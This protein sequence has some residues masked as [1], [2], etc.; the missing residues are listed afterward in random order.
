MFDHLDDTIT[1]P[2]DERFRNQTMRRGRRLRRRRRVAAGATACGSTLLLGAAGLT[3]W[4]KE[5]VDDIDRVEIAGPTLAPPAAP[6]EPTTFLLVGTDSTVAMDPSDPV[7]AG[8]DPHS[9]FA[10]AIML[11]RA[12]PSGDDGRLSILSVP[13]DLWVADVDGSGTPGRIN[14]VLSLG[15]PEQLVRTISSTLDVEVH[16]YIQIDMDGFRD[17]VD[18]AGGIELSFPVGV[19]DTSAGLVLSGG[20]CERLDGDEALALVRSRGQFEVQAS[21]G[22]WTL[23][24]SDDFGR[25]RRQLLVAM[26]ALDSLRADDWR[27]PAGVARAVDLLADHAVLDSGQTLTDLVGWG[28]WFTSTDA[29]VMQATTL[30]VAGA[31]RPDGANVLELAPGWEAAVSTFVDGTGTPHPP[32]AA[33]VDEDLTPADF[34]SRC[35]TR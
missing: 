15:G 3:W 27:S 33:T 21:D 25:T 23:D 10:D 7:A 26:L 35:T 4:G 14:T 8:R 9:N 28:A 12:D 16:H 17:L 20:V 18:G 6:G 32:P 11:V 22:S 24:R 19:R 29:P 5:K 34:P 1:A 2:T 30:P 13:R 31:T